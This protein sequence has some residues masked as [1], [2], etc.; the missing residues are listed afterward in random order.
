MPA[1]DRGRSADLRGARRRPAAD[2]RAG[3]RAA[4]GAALLSVLT[5][6]SLSGSALQ[7]GTHADARAGPA[8]R[9]AAAEPP[10]R[11]PAL[12]ARRSACSSRAE[13]CSATA[14][15][16]AGRGR[17]RSCASWPRPRSCGGSMRRCATACARRLSTWAT[18]TPGPDRP[19][20]AGRTSTITCSTRCCAELGLA[21]STRAAPFEPEAGGYATAPSPFGRGKHSRHHHDFAH[22]RSDRGHERDGADEPRLALVRLLQLA[23]PALPIGAFSY[24]QGLEWVVAEGTVHDAASGGDWIGDAWSSSSPPARRPSP[25]ACSW[26]RRAKTGASSPSGTTGSAHAARPRSCARKPSRPE[27]RWCAWPATLSCSTRRRNSPRRRW[28][29]S[30]CPPPTRCLRAASACRRRRR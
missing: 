12:A 9:A 15:A 4:A 30:P 14:I 20:L 21:R 29:R 8:L 22:A 27:R 25:G 26:P 17:P 28:R 1:A 2:L 7:R 16:C 23:S 11:A 19:R 24:S 13:R 6:C 18:G 10:A 5:P 3:D